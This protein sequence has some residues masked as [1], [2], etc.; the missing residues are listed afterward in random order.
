MTLT[1]SN[2]HCRKK[3]KNNINKSEINPA[4]VCTRTWFL[5]SQSLKL[6]S[7]RELTP[8]GVL[9]KIHQCGLLK[10]NDNSLGTC[11]STYRSYYKSE[12]AINFI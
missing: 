8:T 2:F 11:T 7:G 10:N 5:L 4:G 3:G 1:Y 6:T 9:F 12:T